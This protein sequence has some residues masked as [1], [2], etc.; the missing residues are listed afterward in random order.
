[1]ASPPWAAMISRQ[2]PAIP[3]IASSQPTGSKRPSPLGPTRR[4]GWV[5]RSG[6]CTRSAYSRTLP[7]ITPWV[8]GCSAPVTVVIRP[9]STATSRLQHDGQSWGHTDRMPAIL[10]YDRQDVSNHH[11]AQPVQD[12]RHAPAGDAVRR[13][14]LRPGHVGPAEPADGDHAEGAGAELGRRR[15]LHADLDRPLAHQAP[16][17]AAVGLRAAVRPPAEELLLDHVGA[18]LGLRP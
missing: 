4:R 10:D 16:V 7:Q 18:G 14:L 5:M 8:N 3:A 6:E 13:R 2:W 9:S 15:R 17:R 12:R 1:M 11:P